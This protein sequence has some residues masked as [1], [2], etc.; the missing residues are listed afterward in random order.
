[1]QSMF[2]DHNKIKS[3]VNN[4]DIWKIPR[5][6]EFNNARHGPG[7]ELQSVSGTIL[8]WTRG[9]PTCQDLGRT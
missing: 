8:S 7:E 1:M 9:N 6:L 4:N 5:Q 2:S 3:G